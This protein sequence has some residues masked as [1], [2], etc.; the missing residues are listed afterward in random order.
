MNRKFL[1]RTMTR[2]VMATILALSLGL[3]MIPTQS[4]S[5]AAGSTATEEM[6]EDENYTRLEIRTV[7]DFA[8]FVSQCYIDSWSKDKY[9]VLM[10][11]I[12]LTDAEYETVP[13]FNGIFDGNG[14]TISGFDYVGTGY[15]VGLFRY[16]ESNGIVKDLN[17]RGNIESENEQECIG[18]IAGINYGTIRNCTF[19]GTV[20]GQDTVGGIVGTNEKTGTISNCTSKGRITGYYSTGGVAGINHGAINSCTNRAGVNDNV[21]WVEEDDEMGGVEMVKNLVSSDDDEVYSGVDTG[22]IAGYSDGVIARCTNSGVIG[23]EHTGYNIGGIAGRQAGVVTLCT[24]GRW[25]LI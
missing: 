6:S 24:K 13:V 5:L 17:L 12:D 2:K 7:Q 20:S 16:I 22:G 9:V 19:I 10:E 11:D 25:S 15:V 14:K 18:S 4:V 21:A 8:D 23:Y 3:G 1:K